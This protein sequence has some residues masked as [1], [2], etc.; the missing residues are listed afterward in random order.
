[1]ALL[2]ALL[3]GCSAVRF[4]YNQAP[5]LAF[6]WLDRYVDFDDAQEVRARA[7]IADWFRWHRGTQLSDYAALLAKARAEVGEPVTPAQMC[8]WA[9]DISV[10]MDTAV[11]HALPPL[12][13]AVRALSPQQ[14]DHLARKYEKNLKEYR[15][16]FLQPDMEDRREAQF[17]RVLDR[18][19]MLYGRLSDTQ[20]ERMAQWSAASP[21][22]PEM[23][24]TE[25]QH[26]QQDAL[27]ALRRLSA[28]HAGQDE[29][30]R[31]LK[32]LYDEMMHSPRE[33]HRVYQ[34]RLW[35]YNC[36]FAAQVHNM[37][38]PEQRAHAAKRLKGWED[39][40]RSLAAQTR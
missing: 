6:W 14:L 1:M 4:A 32:R 13:D 3:A 40:M 36:G 20:R 17:K 16:D 21:F 19:E 24:F 29:A 2:L 27:A 8:R 9:D 31:V 11:E 23:W 33:A 26:R 30:Q 15:K 10:R 12:A 37:T 35:Q 7:A 28:E 5:D 18:A 34:E 22:D 25:R 39:D 38:T